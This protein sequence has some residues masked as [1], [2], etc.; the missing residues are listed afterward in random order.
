MSMQIVI[1]GSGLAATMTALA[2]QENLP[3]NVAI[4]LLSTASQ[5]NTDIFY[6]T[7]SAPEIYDFHLSL[8]VSEPE[9]LFGS[10]SSFSFGSYFQ[11][12]ALTDNSWLQCFHLPFAVEQGVGLHHF[13]NRQAPGQ[14]QDYLISAQAA[15]HGKFAHPPADQ[16]HPLSR[17]EYGYHFDPQQW[18][19]LYAA[20]HHQQRINTIQASIAEVVIE[21][22]KI[23]ALVL[24]NGE[25]LS[26]SLFIDCSGP[27]ARLL[28]AL[29]IQQTIKKQLHAV[30]SVKPGTLGPAYRQI[31]STQAGWMADTPFSTGVRR[32]SVYAPTDEQQALACHELAVELQCQV[33]I[34][35]RTQ[36]WAG[37]CVAIGQAANVIE[38]LTPAPHMLLVRDIQ[39]LLELLPLSEDMQLEAREYNRRFADD[40]EHCELFHAALF[41]VPGLPDSDY[42][43]LSSSAASSAKLQ[44]KLSQFNHRGILASFDLEPFNEQDW[45]ILLM[46][47]GQTPQTYDRLAEQVSETQMAVKL[48]QMR[49]IIQQLVAKMPPHAQYMDKLK[50][51]LNTQYSQ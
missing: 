47:M 19:E 9:I 41:S 3:D 1:C 40:A 28:S 44:R 2:L 27:E 17:A 14:F 10:D 49:D 4:T 21:H 8:S 42:W 37:N 11:R 7:S 24:D 50:R 32:L 46:G 20:K 33:N 30:S 35:P 51:Y 39:R 48:A 22:G 13:V 36:A 38:P 23:S 29:D 15:L 16:Q 26:A 5:A 45:T 43:Q 31:I 34:G 18:S 25:T 6:G 12:W